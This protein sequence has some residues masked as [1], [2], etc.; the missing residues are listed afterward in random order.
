MKNVWQIK[1]RYYGDEFHVFKVQ[2]LHFRAGKDRQ[3]G[4]AA[5]ADIPDRVAV[6]VELSGKRITVGADLHTGDTLSGKIKI[7][8]KNT[9]ILLFA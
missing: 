9:L 4:G 2:I 1:N 5:P 8:H 7:T 6:P 3:D